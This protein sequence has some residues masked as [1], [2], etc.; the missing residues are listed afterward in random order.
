ME[1]YLENYRGK[2]V[3]ITGGLGFIGSNLA[4][5]L[6][7]LDACQVAILDAM[8]PGSGANAHNIKG[9][10]GRVEVTIGD[11]RDAELTRRL[12]ERADVIF[13]LVGQV[14]HIDSMCDPLKDLEVNC[15]AHLVLLEACRE[16]NPTVPIVYASTRQIYG[17]PRYLPLDEEHPIEPIDING[18]NKLAAERYHLI[19]GAVY[20]MPVVSLR[21]TNTYGPRQLIRHKRQ[22]FMG[23]FVRQALL[24]EEILIYGDG[25]QRRD[26]NF[27]EDVID[28]LLRAGARPDGRAYNLGG[29]ESWTLLEIAELLI[30]L[31]GKGTYRMVPFPSE[32][33]RIDIGSCYSDYSRAKAVLG[34]EPRVPLEDGLR[35]TFEFYRKNIT[36]YL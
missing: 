26:L 9:L 23:W 3:L 24:G 6:A 14:S 10:E 16:I 7:G 17:R 27:V 8:V 18:V 22:G 36:F 20:G 13:N 4:W 12:I 1:G 33:R 11:L 30:K 35:R 28:A 15:R 29:R 31:A 32:F 34:W 21:L 25:Q 2:R 5:A 19:Y